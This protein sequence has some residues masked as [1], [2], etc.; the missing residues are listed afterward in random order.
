MRHDYKLFR[1][2]IIYLSKK[3]YIYNRIV[4]INMT[5]YIKEL[6]RSTVFQCWIKIWI[7]KNFHN[8]KGT[9]L[10]MDVYVLNK[11]T[12]RIDFPNQPEICYKIKLYSEL[13]VIT[14]IAVFGL[15]SSV[16]LSAAIA[17]LK[18]TNHNSSNDLQM[19]KYF[20]YRA[21]FAALVYLIRCLNPLIGADSSASP[22]NVYLIQLVSL[23][24]SNYVRSSLILITVLCE[25]AAQYSCLMKLNKRFRLF[26][27][28][29]SL[30]LALF[31]IYSFLF[32]SYRL[33]AYEIESSTVR[34]KDEND[35]TKD[36]TSNKG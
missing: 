6:L 13:Y 21:V 28:K 7:I 15:F 22:K 33:L 35:Q 2:S 11:S 12:R 34:N 4:E 14:T 8:T 17:K 20:Q 32:Y 29:D 19:F 10:V 25:I 9:V 1:K 24:V 30:N 26:K 36:S 3:N 18:R 27:S 23:V 5:I 31:I 16:V